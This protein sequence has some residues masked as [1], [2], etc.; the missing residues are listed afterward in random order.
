VFA[1][2]GKIIYQMS[3]GGSGL[4]IA[5]NF[6]GMKP[7]NCVIWGLSANAVQAPVMATF[8]ED[9]S[10]SVVFSIIPTA[11]LSTLGIYFDGIFAVSTSGTLQVQARVSAVAA[12]M[13]IQQGS[14][15]RSRQIA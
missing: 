13:N 4:G 1:I 6:P 10:N 5:F 7:S 11:A 8:N 3:V 2:D 14:Y 9:A 15:I 12:P